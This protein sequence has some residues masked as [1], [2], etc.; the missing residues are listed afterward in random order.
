MT[1]EAKVRRA[2][3]LL[4]RHFDLVVYQNHDLFVEIITRM[5][6]FVPIS[7]RSSNQHMLEINF[8]ID[9][10]R[11]MKQKIYE[12]GDVD[13]INAIRHVYGAHLQ[14]LFGQNEQYDAPTT[15]F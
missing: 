15:S 11:L 6:E 7:L 5:I 4:K 14:Y 3:D 2:M 12:N 8:T 13:W 10:I 9:E 1:R